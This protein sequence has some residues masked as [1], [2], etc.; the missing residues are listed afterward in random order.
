MAEPEHHLRVLADEPGNQALFVQVQ[1]ACEDETPAVQR[2]IY[3]A[4]ANTQH[5]HSPQNP[6]VW[7]LLIAYVYF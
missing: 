5:L 6:I 1:E 2:S 4:H 7:W 3:Q